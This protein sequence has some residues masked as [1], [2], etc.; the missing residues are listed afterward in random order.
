MKRNVLSRVVSFGL[1]VVLVLCAAPLSARADEVREI[2]SG[3]A[4]TAKLTPA[5]IVALLS[6]GSAGELMETRPGF[7]SPW[8]AGSVRREHLDGALARLNA[9]RRIAG[10]PSVALDCDYTELA[11]AAAYLNALKGS[12]G[13]SSDMPEGMPEDLYK[14]GVEG[15]SKSIALSSASQSSSPLSFSVDMWMNDSGSSSVDRLGNRRWL[16]NPTMDKTGFGAVPAKTGSGFFSAQYI[17]GMG[18]KA[19][20]YDIIAWPAS[21]FFPSSGIFAANQ[22]WSVTLNPE[23]YA[24]PSRSDVTVTLTRQ[25]DG[26]VWTFRGSGYTPSNS[27][28][29]FNVDT[30]S[31]G[32]NNC[33]IFRPA[34][35]SSYE[36]SYTVA[37]SGV[38]FLAGGPADFKYTVSFFDPEKPSGEPGTPF[39]DVSTGD[40][41]YPYVKAG[42]ELGLIY[43]TSPTTFSP[44]S[45]LT[46]AQVV[47]FAART[48]A[49][50][51]GDTD[52][53]LNDWKAGAYDYCVVNGY[54]SEIELPFASLDREATRLE[55]VRIMDP[56]I[57][58][59]VFSDKVSIPSGS[60]PDVKESDPYG[61]MIYRWYRAGLLNG[62]GSG[63]F[64]GGGT[65]DRSA[66]AA[67][68]CRINGV[69]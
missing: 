61:T 5:Q 7:A 60:I 30:T 59:S 55:M 24:V 36:G 17:Y 67:V 31:Y 64:S 54:I 48:A 52:P 62:T 43:G 22:A 63:A 50:F 26:R 66:M 53:T 38:K 45:K 33:I 47:A 58:K 9:V 3:V 44:Q 15:M 29:Y 11:Q 13:Q 57:P 40:W 51:N 46:L 16:L 32:V 1:S 4:G 68:L 56:V 37:V 18:G 10:L 14:K 19:P 65:M 6:S 28:E 8:S 69:G 2:E 41:F 25:S 23:I 35:I 12:L 20:D 34:G 39:T 21:G 27:G 42:S 49:R